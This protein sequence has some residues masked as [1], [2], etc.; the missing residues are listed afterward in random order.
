METQASARICYETLHSSGTVHW[1]AAK[2]QTDWPGLIA[3]QTACD[4]GCACSEWSARSASARPRA[5]LGPA[6]APL[7]GGQRIPPIEPVRPLAHAF[8]SALGASSGSG[9]GTVPFVG[10]KTTLLKSMPYES[11][12]RIKSTYYLAHIS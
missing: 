10:I 1:V 9:P 2:H 6:P 4:A 7:A 12:V 8:R 3:L 5:H 11:T